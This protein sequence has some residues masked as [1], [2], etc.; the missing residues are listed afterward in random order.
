[1]TITMEAAGKVRQRAE[2]AYK[3]TDRKADTAKK[4]GMLNDGNGLYLRVR[5]NGKTISKS[6]IF[7]FKPSGAKSS[8][9]LGLGAYPLVSL[10]K[11]REKAGKA[12]V[13]VNEGRDPVAERKAAQVAEA[14]A[15]DAP[16]GWTFEE[17]AKRCIA[18]NET[19][20]R[21]AKHRG[22]WRSTLATYAAPVIGSKD[23][24]GIGPDDVLTILAPIWLTKE[25]TASRLRA[26]IETVF[27]FAIAEGKADE[28][29]PALLKKLK[30]RLPKRP[31]QE[32][33]N[34]FAALSWREMPKL[35]AALRKRDGAASKALQFTILTCARTGE[36]LHATWPEIDLQAREWTV[37]GARM[38]MG[39]TH[40]QPITDEAAGLLIEVAESGS[41][42]LF[43]GARKGRPLSSMAML[44][45]LDRMGYGD[46]ATVH[47]FRSTFSD[48]ASECTDFK[49][50]VSEFAL[51]HKVGSKV[52]RAYK[53]STR[54][55]QRRELL[56]QWAEYLNGV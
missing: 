40:V 18:M 5:A 33:E 42:Y 44:N 47:G 30:P 29:N 24:R 56:K 23:V 45:L 1:M 39:K 46:R 22:Q 55:E 19:G 16:C 3:L 35:M 26:R 32:E 12:R 41:A 2:G 6:W 14:A 21:N 27:D 20:W 50:A 31:K 53:R 17:A 10:A 13:A 38:K 43:P 25:Q 28:P 54:F 8:R 34:H 4:P 49:D 51:A 11:A 52:S 36:V 15:T 37:P 9:D 7:R 48:W